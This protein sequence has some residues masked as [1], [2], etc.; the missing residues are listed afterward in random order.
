MLE[1]LQHWYRNLTLEDALRIFRQA[2]MFGGGYA[3]GRGYL[4]ADQVVMLT[5]VGVSLISFLW[6]LRANTVASK[7]AEVNKSE[8]VIVKATP[9]ASDAVKEAVKPETK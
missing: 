6:S 8:E 1:N 9:L 4:S 7:A 5:G 2:A 3:T